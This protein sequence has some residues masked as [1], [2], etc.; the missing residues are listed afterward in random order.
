MD[1]GRH[2]TGGHEKSL[3]VEPNATRCPQEIEFVQLGYEETRR[4]KSR[5]HFARATRG[6][7]EDNPGALW[8]DTPREREG[9]TRRVRGVDR[10]AEE[11][12]SE[13]ENILNDD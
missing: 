3:L 7:G 10:I 4:N 12:E 1:T 2:S 13:V 9:N 6:K 5:G 11:K 8:H